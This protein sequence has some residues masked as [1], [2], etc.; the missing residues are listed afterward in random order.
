MNP[1]TICSAQSAETDVM[2]NIQRP[3]KFYRLI[4]IS[5]LTTMSVTA[6]TL[7]QK[8]GTRQMPLA[9][10]VVIATGGACVFLASDLST[11]STGIALDANGGMLIH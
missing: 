5:R 1:P 10:R 3:L 7:H 4:V 8:R 6:S 11:Y 2:K 9:H